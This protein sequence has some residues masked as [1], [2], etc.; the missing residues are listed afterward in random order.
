MFFDFQ[1]NN[2][3]PLIKEKPKMYIT[4]PTQIQKC[5]YVLNPHP[6]MYITYPIHVQNCTLRID[7]GYIYVHLRTHQ[8][9][10]FMY[11]RTQ[12][13]FFLRVEKIKMFIFHL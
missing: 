1:K 9:M 10:T 3:T 11:S 5:T 12:E 2:I 8:Q 4:Y 13:H 7:N 6:K